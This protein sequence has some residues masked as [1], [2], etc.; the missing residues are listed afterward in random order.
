[1][2]VALEPTVIESVIKCWRAELLE[3]VLQN[4][5]CG[6]FAIKPAF[7]YLSRFI[8]F[9]KK[10]PRSVHRHKLYIEPLLLFYII[11]KA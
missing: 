9:F 3:V 7:S 11:L 10:F 5:M 6:W 8:A 4:C 2:E 1:M